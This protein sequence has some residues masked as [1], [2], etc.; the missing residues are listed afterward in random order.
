MFSKDAITVYM[1]NQLKH[2][3]VKS[4]IL[5]FYDQLSFGII[6]IFNEEELNNKLNKI[7]LDIMDE[8]T[9]L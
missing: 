8:N 7:G 5:Y 2:I 4:S 1:N 9:T 6:I 3:N